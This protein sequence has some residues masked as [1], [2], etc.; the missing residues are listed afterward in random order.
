MPPGSTHA[1]QL[2]RFDETSRRA[3]RHPGAAPTRWQAAVLATSAALAGVAISEM[4]LALT[5]V[6]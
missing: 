1:A 6:T 3:P 4:R 2:P 5:W